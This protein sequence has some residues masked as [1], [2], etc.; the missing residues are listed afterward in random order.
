MGLVALDVAALLLNVFIQLIACDMDQ[1][2][3]P[4]VKQVSRVL[5]TAG[6]VFSCLFMA[7]LIV[8]LLSFGSRL[9]S[10]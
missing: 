5:E 10:Q 6:L 9:V 7:E 8:S 4:W 2:E 1:R 3:E